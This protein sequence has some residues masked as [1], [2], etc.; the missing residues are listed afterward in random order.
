MHFGFPGF[1]VFM[2]IL[3]HHGYSCTHTS[4]IH[5]Q[6]HAIDSLRD[7]KSDF[8]EF[9]PISCIRDIKSV[10]QE[11]VKLRVA[12]IITPGVK[13]LIQILFTLSQTHTDH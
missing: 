6:V 4:T 7:K 2:P 10:K 13:L 5:F 9:R 12:S 8:L 1:Y 3:C 11:S